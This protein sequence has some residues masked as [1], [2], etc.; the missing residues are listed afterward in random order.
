MLVVWEPL[1]RTDNYAAAQ[2]S[3]GLIP[4]RR[5]IHYWEPGHVMGLEMANSSRCPEA[6]ILPWTC[7]ALRLGGDLE[8]HS[9]PTPR[10]WFHKFGDDERTFSP[11][12]LRADETG[13]GS[14]AR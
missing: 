8:R 12:K 4:D 10:V 3:A 6:S 11:E 5:A 2:K 7:S 1:L 14:A 9:L 13:S